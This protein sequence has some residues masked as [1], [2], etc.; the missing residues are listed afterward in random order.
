MKTVVFGIFA[1]IITTSFNAQSTFAHSP[2]FE[3]STT[4]DILKFCEFFY[5]KYQL[6]ST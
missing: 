6:L 1:N 3:M 5:E 4:E 2:D